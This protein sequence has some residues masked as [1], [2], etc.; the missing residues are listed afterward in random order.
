MKKQYLT[1][2]KLFLLTCIGFAF[3]SSCGNSSGNENERAEGTVDRPSGTMMELEYADQFSLEK[4]EDGSAI[5][6]IADGLKYLVISDGAEAPA[7][8]EGKYTII[9]KPLDS[10]Y[11]AAS[12][13]FDLFM[14]IGAEG[15][16]SMT[17][18]KAS[19]WGI[20]EIKALVESEETVYVGK[21]SAPDYETLLEFECDIAIESTMIY[22]SPDTKEKIEDLNIPV[23]IE[24]SSYER[25]PLG[26]L[27]WIKLFGFLADKEEEAEDFFNRMA[28]KYRSI[29]K[30]TEG[31]KEEDRPEVA[32]FSIS[33]NNYATVRKPGDYIS[34][35]I[36][37]AGGVY[38]MKDL[39]VADE[40]ALS[41]TNIQLESFYDYVVDS[42]ILIYNTA[43][44][45]EIKTKE[46]LIDKFSELSSTKAC[47]NGEIWAT[48][49]SVFQRASGVADMTEELFKIISGDGEDEMEYFIKLK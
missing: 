30:A 36:Y 46:E 12:S 47:E 15:S 41:T 5:I 26:R 42:D 11:L 4:M 23:L 40:N 10:I 8:A 22:H 19:D 7:W 6:E 1:I 45:G 13:A 16:I 24:R 31:K 9:R 28:D 14:R 35:M 48:R 2:V 3:L 18:T 39:P 43:I 38:A 20:D 37:L 17:S 44:Q 34:K 21:Y 32:F 27:E 49:K 29:I 33:A 25:E